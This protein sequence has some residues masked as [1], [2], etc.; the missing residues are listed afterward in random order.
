MLEDADLVELASRLEPFTPTGAAAPAAVYSPA[1]LAAELGRSERSIRGAIARGELDAVRRGRGWVISAEAVT[2][3]AAN[4]SRG[5]GPGPAR[6][7][8][9]SR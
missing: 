4:G 5:S 1:T 6:R 9:R 8:L 2:E 3:W 7:A